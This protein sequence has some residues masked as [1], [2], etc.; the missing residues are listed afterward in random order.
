[1]DM[2]SLLV[3][4][5]DGS[6]GAKMQPRALRSKA[7]SSASGGGVDNWSHN[8]RMEIENPLRS[9]SGGGDIEQLPT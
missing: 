1:M 4:K 2:Y 3:H 6:I 5:Q 8:H 9:L 7:T